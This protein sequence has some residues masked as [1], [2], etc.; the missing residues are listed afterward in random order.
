[1]LPLNDSDQ[2][3]TYKTTSFKVVMVFKSLAILSNKQKE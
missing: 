1:M 3:I 2:K